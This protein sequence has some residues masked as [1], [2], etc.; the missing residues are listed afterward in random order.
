MPRHGNGAILQ[1]GGR[2]VYGKHIGRNGTKH[3]PKEEQIAVSVPA[4]I[5]KETW[6][7]AEQVRHNNR[8][9][10]KHSESYDYLLKG[11]IFCK[12]AGIAWERTQRMWMGKSMR[13]TVVILTEMSWRM[14]AHIVQSTTRPSALIRLFGN[15]SL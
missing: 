14:S 2:M 6:D 4:I 13:T 15:G 12:P 1:P 5:S 7:A 8:S 10:R 9:E 11:H 3:R